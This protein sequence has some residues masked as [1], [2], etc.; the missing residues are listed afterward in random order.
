LAQ[1]VHV[2]T[3]VK[4][5]TVRRPVRVPPEPQLH[6][7]A[8]QSYRIACEPATQGVTRYRTAIPSSL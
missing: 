2:A 6:G 7:R 3:L 5:F 4:N 1:E 8:A